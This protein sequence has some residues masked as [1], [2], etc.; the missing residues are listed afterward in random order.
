MHKFVYR[1]SPLTQLHRQQRETFLSNKLPMLCL[2]LELG[3]KENFEE[4]KFYLACISAR[5]SKC[6]LCSRIYICLFVNSC[7]LKS[8]LGH[9]VHWHPTSLAAGE[10][11]HSTGRYLANNHVLETASTICHQY[12]MSLKPA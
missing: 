5:Q 12:Q 7:T 3:K 8:V 2:E 10:E 11:Q 9:Q 1:G 6:I 4:T